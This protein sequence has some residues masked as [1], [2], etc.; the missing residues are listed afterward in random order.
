MY[1]QVPSS[2][3]KEFRWKKATSEQD[4]LVFN[5]VPTLKA[6][7]SLLQQN[8]YVSRVRLTER[9][10]GTAQGLGRL[11]DCLVGWPND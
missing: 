1:R 10:E 4:S 11:S 5:A 8:R 9:V 7:R 2:R 3:E 6:A